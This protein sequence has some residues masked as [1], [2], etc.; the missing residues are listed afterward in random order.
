VDVCGYVGGQSEII[1]ICEA[2][3][4]I[5]NKYQAYIHSNMLQ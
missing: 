1:L 5:L 2:A 4:F 3:A